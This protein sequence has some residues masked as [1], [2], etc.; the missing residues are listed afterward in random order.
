M[1]GLRQN[2]PTIM[3]DSPTQYLKIGNFTRIT[4]LFPTG[5]K[6]DTLYIVTIVTHPFCVGTVY[7]RHRDVSKRQSQ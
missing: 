3:M 6:Y 2:Y 1:H 5:F 4:D 7:D